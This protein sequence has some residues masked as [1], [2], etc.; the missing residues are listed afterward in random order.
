[1]ILLVPLVVVTNEECRINL[2]EAQIAKDAVLVGVSLLQPLQ[3]GCK[4]QKA[5]GAANVKKTISV[6]DQIS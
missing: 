4:E 5:C 2:S 6:I 3:P 1:M